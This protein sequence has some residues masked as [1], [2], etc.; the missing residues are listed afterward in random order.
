MA[1]NDKDEILT[2]PKHDLSLLPFA[3]KQKFR[4]DNTTIHPAC[5]SQKHL[6]D[7]FA[8]KGAPLNLDPDNPVQILINHGYVCGFSP[9]RFQPSWCAYRIANATRD[10]KYDR[11]HIYYADKRLNAKVRLSKKTFGKHK[12]IGYHVGHMVPNEAINTQF[13]R[14]AQLETFFMSNMSPQRGTLNTGVWLD[15]ENIIRKIKDTKDKDHVWAFVGTIFDED[16][17]LISRDQ[18]AV[19]IPSHYFCVMID[20]HSYPW[21]TPSTVAIASFI[22]PQDAPKKTPLSMFEVTLEEVEEATN[23]DF[24]P[25]WRVEFPEGQ[26]TDIRRAAAFIKDAPMDDKDAKDIRFCHRLLQLIKLAD[27]A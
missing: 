10:V 23:L 8:F 26:M 14:L 20:P 21:D 24:F 18:V 9:N 2:T 12:K 5:Y 1:A 25:G 17:E 6:I 11:P 27:G 16:P 7:L 13:G 22:I 4:Q 15:L 19:P 3:A